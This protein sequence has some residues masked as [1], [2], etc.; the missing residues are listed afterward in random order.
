MTHYQPTP[1][2]RNPLLWEIAR[3][4]ASFKT[5]SVTY[6]IVIPFLWLIWI[7]TSFRHGGL[8]AYPWP[9]WPTIGWAIGLAIHYAGA[10]VFPQANTTEKEYDKLTNKK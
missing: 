8:D 9:I 4:R 5:N 3:K 6:F 7:I 1:E 10:Y 2:G